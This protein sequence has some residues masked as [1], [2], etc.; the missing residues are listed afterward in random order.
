MENY[1]SDTLRE[2]LRLLYFQADEARFREG[3][4]LLEQAVAKG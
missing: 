2:G 3:V 4:E 1:Y